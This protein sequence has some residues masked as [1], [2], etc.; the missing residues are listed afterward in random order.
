MVVPANNRRATITGFNGERRSSVDR[1]LFDILSSDRS[2]P[3]T[4]RLLVAGRLVGTQIPFK[5]NQ[6]LTTCDHND[7]APNGYSIKT[8][9]LSNRSLDQLRTAT[10]HHLPIQERALT[11]S[12][13]AVSKP[14]EG[15][16]TPAGRPGRALI[17]AR[18]TACLC[19]RSNYEHLNCSNFN[20]RA[21]ITAA[22]GTR[23]DINSILAQGS[24]VCRFQLPEYARP[25]SRPLTDQLTTRLGELLRSARGGIFTATAASELPRTTF[26][27]VPPGFGHVKAL[28][29]ENT[30]AAS[31][32]ELRRLACG[33]TRVAV[34]APD[35]PSCEHRPATF[36]NCL[37]GDH[38]KFRIHRTILGRQQ[39]ENESTSSIDWV[40]RRAL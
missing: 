35:V 7:G 33:L 32:S 17:A 19:P 23:L 21:G 37:L 27:W 5:M 11:L 16:L 12:I 30:E 10:H 6:T 38:C 28:R 22:A 3:L 40:R 24:K 20:I 9:K 31:D 14:S 34:R 36:G 29:I 8:V 25:A 1:A 18:R 2:P 13:L 39:A 15:T 26:D 4:P